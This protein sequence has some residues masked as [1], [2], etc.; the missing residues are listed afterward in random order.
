MKKKVAVIGSTG[1]IGTNSLDV[2][3]RHSGKFEVVSLAAMKNWELLAAQALKFKPQFVAIADSSCHAKLESALTGTGIKIGSGEEAAIQAASHP[4][5]D[6]II[7]AISGSDGLKPT[8]RAIQSGKVVALANKESLAMAGRLI[9]ST[10]QKH[11]TTILPVDSEHS[12]V[13]Q[14]LQSGKK[15]EVK[16]IILTA[17]GGPF[18]NYEPL[19]LRSIT[20]AEAMKHPV[21]NMGSKISVDSATMAN[22]GIEVMEAVFL[23]DVPCDE[24]DVV[25]HPQSIIHSMV[26]YID[27]SVIAQM[28]F[29]DMRIPIQY[30][31]T[32]P[33]RD[34]GN[35]SGRI[36]NGKTE[37]H[38]LQ[39]KN[40]LFPALPLAYR[41][42]K[43]GD[44]GTIAYNAADETAVRAFL[45]GELR[46]DEISL[47]IQDALDHTK[48][49]IINSIDEVIDYGDQIKTSTKLLIG[50]IHSQK[51]H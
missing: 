15:C 17:S 33:E 41:A 45:Q 30:A 44:Y 20:P 27:G 13:F 5:A 16:R 36:F 43:M 12:A 42:I 28:G 26:E 34:V 38:F 14:A 10:A 32:W 9:M 48:P 3:E 21:W 11:G 2:I 50:E 25:I 24:I 37:M 1:S 35:N 31:L 51:R 23:F 46:F 47:V 40:D 6:I 18:F 4:E 29:P 8:F 7:S 22:K 19:S 49:V 39:P